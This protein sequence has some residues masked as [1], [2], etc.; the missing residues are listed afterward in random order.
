MGVFTPRGLALGVIL[1]ARVRPKE[2]E[3]GKGGFGFFQGD[4][5]QGV[6]F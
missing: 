2:R 3:R 4:G 6:L 1:Q 5:P